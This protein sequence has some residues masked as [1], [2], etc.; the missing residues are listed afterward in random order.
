M[1]TKSEDYTAKEHGLLN[2]RDRE[3][4]F[5][6]TVTL[7]LAG[8]DP[9]TCGLKVD[10][11]TFQ[12]MRSYLEK[13]NKPGYDVFWTDIRDALP[14]DLEINLEGAEEF[15]QWLRKYYPHMKDYLLYR[16]IYNRLPYGP[17]R[18]LNK[19]YRILGI[20]PRGIR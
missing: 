11:S 19:I 7:I 14:D 15:F 17:A 4:C 2:D 1:C 8:I 5:R 13:M 16:D 6:T 12:R 18:F 3:K 10:E 20:R 9:N